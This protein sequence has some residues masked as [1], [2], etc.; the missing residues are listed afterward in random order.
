MSPAQR[1]TF[2]ENLIT[3]AAELITVGPREKGEA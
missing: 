2:L 3:N 1:I